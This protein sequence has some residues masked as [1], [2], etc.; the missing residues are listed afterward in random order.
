[1]MVKSVEWYLKE[2][3]INKDLCKDDNLFQATGQILLQMWVLFL[4]DNRICYIKN[5]KDIANYVGI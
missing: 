5:L 4:T 3:L 1:M 2:K